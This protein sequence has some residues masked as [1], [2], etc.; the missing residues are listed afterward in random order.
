MQT[1][2]AAKAKKIWPPIPRLKKNAPIT[3]L[4]KVVRPSTATPIIDLKAIYPL[5]LRSILKSILPWLASLCA[6]LGLYV[7]WRTLT[8]D[9]SRALLDSETDLTFLLW[10][11][12]AGGI[13]VIKALYAALFRMTIRYRLEEDNLII[14]KGVFLRQGTNFPLRRINNIAVRRD[15]LDYLLGLCSVDFASANNVADFGG[16]IPGF[17]VHAGYGLELYMRH[18]V[19]DLQQSESG[20]G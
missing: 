1:T 15:V 10:F 13:I 17:G 5:S 11:L 16:T 4:K 12:L 18:L 7:L 2:S 20:G 14:R 19:N 9:P 8:S 3:N 6:L